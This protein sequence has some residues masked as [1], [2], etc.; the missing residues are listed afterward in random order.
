MARSQGLT[1]QGKLRRAP[2]LPDEI[3]RLLRDEIQHGMLQ[4][5]DRLPTE[6]QLCQRFGVSRPVVR[7]AV[8]RLK[9]DGLLQSFQGRGVFVAAGD[10]RSSFRLDHPDLNDEGELKHILELLVTIEVAATGLAA[11]RRSKR[12]LAAIKQALLA[13]GAAIR[14]GR[15]GVDEDYRFHT[16]IVAATGN[17]FFAGLT[18]FLE[19]RVRNLIRAAR[20]NTAR[21]EG[22]ADK[23][24]EEHLAVYEAIASSDTLAAQQAAER[25]LRNAAARLRLYRTDQTH[26]RKAG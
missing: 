5:G 24:Q 1:A 10:D 19:S 4:P 22:L 23:V 26:A 11:E 14:E 2:G 7:E 20:A 15:S 9:S 12:Q 18:G 17:P 3:A 16:E 13:M 8:S 25:H 6:Q 21:F